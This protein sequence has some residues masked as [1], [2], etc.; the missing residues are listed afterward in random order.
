MQVRA[1]TQRGK[2]VVV[3]SDKSFTDSTMKKTFYKDYQLAKAVK[4]KAG[5]VFTVKY[6]KNEQVY[7]IAKGFQVVAVISDDDKQEMAQRLYD[8]VDYASSR[9]DTIESIKEAILAA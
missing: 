5:E 3:V 9:F 2:I 4:V 6:P 8:R 7:E 1:K